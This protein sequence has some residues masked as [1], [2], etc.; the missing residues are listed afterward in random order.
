M[1]CI[2]EYNM[3]LLQSVVGATPGDNQPVL[4]RLVTGAAASQQQAPTPAPH[5]AQL[6]TLPGGQ[7]AVVSAPPPKPT[8]AIGANIQGTCSTAYTCTCISI[9]LVRTGLLGV[10]LYMG[11]RR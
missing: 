3:C 11:V 4:A 8:G 10:K 7:R 5:A 9:M 1:V 6:I 2:D